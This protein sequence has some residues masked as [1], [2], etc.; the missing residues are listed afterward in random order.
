[1]LNRYK[2]DWLGGNKT[3]SHQLVVK[4]WCILFK[5]HFWD[6]DGNIVTQNMVSL[7]K[8]NH[9]A[10]EGGILLSSNDGT[11][12]C[13]SKLKLTLADTCEMFHVV[14]FRKQKY[15]QESYFYMKQPWKPD[16][17]EFFFSMV[18]FRKGTPP[19]HSHRRKLK[20][21]KTCKLLLNISYILSLR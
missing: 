9:H 21:R 12:S 8:S 10:I 6:L 5:C 4:A 16:N 11:I 1:M 17:F 20:I 7:I 15:A 19:T 14:V 13:P 2:V 18:V 3:G